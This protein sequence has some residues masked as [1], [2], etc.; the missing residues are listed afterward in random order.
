[1]TASLPAALLIRKI[2]LNAK[3]ARIL[4]LPIT[5]FMFFVTGFL[6]SCFYYNEINEFSLLATQN[7]FLKNSDIQLVSFGTII[8]KPYQ[9]FDNI[10]FEFKV[11]SLEI[12]D[13]N[14]NKS[15]LF[16]D[17]GN[18]F[19][20]YKT[21]ESN[22]FGLN[23]Y[24]KLD[25][26][27]IDRYSK[28]NGSISNTFT[29]SYIEHIKEQVCLSFLYSFRAK[30]HECLSYLFLK[31]LSGQNAS[32]A[33]ALILGIQSNIS[34]EI[35][36]SFKKSGIYHILAIS[37]LHIS[38]IALFILQTLKKIFSS[39]RTAKIIISSIIVFFLI[40]Y[41]FIVGEK[42]SMLRATIM[43]CL[44]FFSKDIFKDYSQSNVLLI[45]YM[46]LLFARPDYLTNIGFILSFAS[47]AALT[48]ISPIIKKC[49]IYFLKLKNEIN[50]YFIRSIIAAFSINL[51]ILPILS[52]YYVGF[53][54]ISIFTNMAAA[55]VF[56]ILI[57][58]LFIS[59]IASVIW[60][61]SGFFLMLPADFLM[62]MIIRI[63]EFFNSLPFGYIKTEIFEKKVYICL[64]Y[65]ALMVIFSTASLFFK[66]R[67][68]E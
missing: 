68:K 55:P 12:F 60:F 5:V 67:L 47:V 44:V 53:S 52:H 20:K 54:L 28:D 63:S 59:S 8:S 17:C 65:F 32:L 7:N 61:P 36:E 64:Y 10:F 4:F 33:A 14:T 57:L 16:G 45:T 40:F 62:N 48:Y 66:K 31:C 43:F 34:H 11:T 24:V 26:V 50:N 30:I 41:N 56:F 9:K 39:G 42:A 2:C 22:S 15:A 29:A 3:K 21:K 18:I 19:I 46:I 58:D 23:D 1:M 49:L 51:F 13:K 25:I 27:K 37:G 38:I 35:T 6:S